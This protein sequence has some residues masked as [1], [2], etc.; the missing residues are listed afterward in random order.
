MSVQ[1]GALFKFRPPGWIA[2]VTPG[3]FTCK[4]VQ[5]FEKFAFH[6]KNEKLHFDTS[7]S[8]FVF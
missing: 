5:Y 4:L 1:N 7:V 2:P 3:D 8:F 6:L